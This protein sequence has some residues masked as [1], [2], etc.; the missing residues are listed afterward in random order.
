MDLIPMENSAVQDAK[1][2]AERLAEMR[3]LDPSG[4][5]HAGRRHRIAISPSRC[6]LRQRTMFPARRHETECHSGL[7][8]PSGKERQASPEIVEGFVCERTKIGHHEWAKDRPHLP[9]KLTHPTIVAAATNTLGDQLACG[10]GVPSWS[11]PPRATDQPRLCRVIFDTHRPSQ[12]VREGV[13]LAARGLRAKNT[14]APGN[15]RH[16][17]KWPDLSRK[18]VAAEST[19][20]SIPLCSPL[21]M[22]GEDNVRLLAL[23]LR[24]INEPE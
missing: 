9:L 12:P 5:R 3:I 16:C 10:P 11:D 19:D 7:Q 23:P 4:I 24:L 1:A 15:I 8:E 22:P 13:F 14:L 2:S 6:T 18:G 17:S 20:R 21:R